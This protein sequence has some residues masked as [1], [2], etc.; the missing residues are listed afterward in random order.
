MAMSTFSIKIKQ[1]F[2]RF[3]RAYIADECPAKDWELFE[4]RN[5]PP[6]NTPSLAVSTQAPF[7]SY[8]HAGFFH[9]KPASLADG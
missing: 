8:H 5:I 6:E 4:G 3:W 1:S 9:V 2:G 7:P